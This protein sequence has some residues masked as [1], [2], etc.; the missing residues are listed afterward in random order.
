MDDTMRSLCAVPGWNEILWFG[1]GYQSFVRMMG[2]SQ[3]GLNC[4]ALCSCLTEV[5]SEE[6]AARVFQELWQL[7]EFPESY[8]PSYSQILALVK[9]CSGVLARSEFSSVLDAMTGHGLWKFGRE[10]VTT[11]ILKASNARDIA[12]ALDALFKITRNRVDT[13]TLLGQNECAFIAA[14]AHWLFDLAIYVED[15][16]GD[17][18]FKSRAD[19]H[20]EGAQVLIIYS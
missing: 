3:L 4:I 15:D 18:L 9:A 8:E 11:S 14:V 1:F 7:N 2:Q 10:R 16:A 6:T 20:R 5:H 19:L 13:I 17:V 12:T